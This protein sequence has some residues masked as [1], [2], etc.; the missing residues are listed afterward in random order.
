LGEILRDFPVSK[1]S[2]TR[3]AKD[4]KKKLKGLRLAWGD[5]YRD[6]KTKG[7]KAI[8]AVVLTAWQWYQIEK[9]SV[10]DTAE[11]KRKDALLKTSTLD[12][13]ILK[14]VATRLRNQLILDCD[15]KAAVQLTR[16]YVGY[17][18]REI[19]VAF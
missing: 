9:L 12:Q 18:Q 4:L 16:F 14:R 19:D 3:I 11:G 7:G 17:A 6:R 13:E 2:Q 10:I 8:A 1:G 15:N 5:K